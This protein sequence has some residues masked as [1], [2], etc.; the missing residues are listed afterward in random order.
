MNTAPSAV[1]TALYA[2]PNAVGHDP[3]T[4][5]NVAAAQIMS[6]WAKVSAAE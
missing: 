1:Y 5:R 4:G 6:P 2:R 3:A